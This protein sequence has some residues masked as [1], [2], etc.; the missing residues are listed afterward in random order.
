[1]AWRRL[2]A[3]GERACLAPRTLYALAE[4]IVA[5]ID[6]LSADSIEGYAREQ[7]AAAGALQRRRQ[8]L[9][10]LL[11]QEPPAAAAAVEAAAADAAWRLPRVLSALVV[12]ADDVDARDTGGAPAEQA[13][14]LA[15]RL[16]PE[17]LVAQVAP[18]VVAV[19]P[20]PALRSELDAAVSASALSADE[21]AALDAAH[22]EV[23]AAEEEVIGRRRV[24]AN[25]VSTRSSA[26]RKILPF[27]VWKSGLR[28]S[29]VCRR[30]RLPKNPVTWARF[31]SPYGLMR[32]ARS[33][34][35]RASP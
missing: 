29:W 21:R 30:N 18:Y 7:A 34:T 16:G 31:R 32:L 10:A 35:P 24:S 9:A 20:A 14:R 2:A 27:T 17:A 19:V 28:N 25:V 8:R 1:M 23:L 6:E 15:L 3:A 11:V 12:E 33:A 4:A 26:R 22:A 13:D 5:Y